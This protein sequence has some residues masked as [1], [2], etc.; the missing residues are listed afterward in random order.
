MRIT[1]DPDFDLGGWPGPLGSGE[2]RAT[3]GEAWAGPIRL[4]GHLEAALGL[5]GLYPTPAERI[6]TLAAVLRDTEGFWSDS[7]TKDP[8]G[9]A[10]VLLRWLDWLVQH[11]WDGR[12]PEGSEV[13]RRLC[14][15]ASLHSQMPPGG[16]D[17][18]AAILKALGKRRADIESIESREPISRLT[19]VWRQIFAKLAAQGVKVTEIGEPH[20]AASAASDLG[21]ALG[22]IFTP[23]ADGTLTLFR[24]YNPLDAAESVAVWLASLSNRSGVVVISPDAVLDEGLR[25]FGL[26]ALGS[27]ESAGDDPWLQVLPLVLAMGWN[28]PDPQRALELLLLA[29]GPVPGKIAWRLR[30]A[31]REWPSVG[32]PDWVRVLEEELKAMEGEARRKALEERLTAIFRPEAEVGEAFPKGG[33]LARAAVVRAWAASR[34]NV[35]PEPPQELAAGMDAIILQ[36]GLFQTLVELNGAPAF[37]E[38]QILKL[39]AQATESVRSNRRYEAQ[40]GLAAVEAPEAMAGPARI[41]LWWDF[42]QDAAREPFALPLSAAELAGLESIGVRLT[43]AAEMAADQARRR[44]RPFLCASETL[45]LVCPVFGED[46]EERHPH[47]VW[48]EVLARIGGEADKTGLETRSLKPHSEPRTRKDAPL[49]L[50]AARRDWTAAPR[51]VSIPERHSPTALQN[52]IGCPFK[53]TLEYAGKLREPE[54]AA[55]K[56]D[57]ALLGSL[58]HEILA[59]VMRADPSDPEEARLKAGELF[60]TLG[61]KLAAPLFR[62]GAPIQSAA[63]RKITEDAARE[64]TAILRKA[65]LH[66]K[67]I[68]GWVKGRSGDLSLNGRVDMLACDPP[69]VVDLKWRGDTYHKDKLKGG[70]AVQLAAYGKMLAGK[71][72]IPPAAYFIISTQ[73]LL[74]QEGTPFKGQDAIGGPPP[75]ETWAATEASVRER[76]AEIGEGRVQATAVGKAGLPEKENGVVKEDAL[77]GG[78]IRLAPPCGFCSFGFLCGVDWEAGR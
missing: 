43:P 72:D 65:K 39:T 51:S 76:L 5:T 36:C 24:P 73:R 41:A 26:P 49:P 74:A 60:E 34:R 28:P 15:L 18:L 42:T 56:G 47:P 35:K 40:A 37:G 7:T 77:E 11:G 64:L 21:R 70:T 12:V 6:A 59:E 58:A 54:S 17:R 78:R 75:G 2:K 52:L 3:V 9:S 55:L 29:D 62:P 10:R 63:V 38:P 19:P 1:F 8:L 30:G 25:R 44:R 31:L 53:W 13:P 50:P 27:R 14:D 68:E 66:V 69:V 71:G 46:G 61:P 23:A 33:L 57:A 67:E 4:R 32:S 22:N 45:V 48:D 20:P 16:A